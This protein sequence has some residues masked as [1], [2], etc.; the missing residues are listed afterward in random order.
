MKIHIQCNEN[1]NVF[2]FK[3][4]TYIHSTYNELFC[5]FENTF[6]QINDIEYHHVDFIKQR[7]KLFNQMLYVYIQVV[8]NLVRMVEMKKIAIIKLKITDSV[9]TCKSIVS[10]P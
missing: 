3:P 4:C 7:N 10:Q 5:P 2:H 8:Q 1:Q 6:N 9:K